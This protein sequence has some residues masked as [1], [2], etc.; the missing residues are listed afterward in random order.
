MFILWQVLRL[1]PGLVFTWKAPAWA[2]SWPVSA[3]ALVMPT[4]KYFN[5]H[6]WSHQGTK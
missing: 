6:P 4:V 1:H 3:A 2:A 5:Y